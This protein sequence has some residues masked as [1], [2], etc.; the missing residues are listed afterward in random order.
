MMNFL[1]RVLRMPRVVLTVM[2]LLL[3]A[4]FGE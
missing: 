2:G 1:E 4:G 3:L